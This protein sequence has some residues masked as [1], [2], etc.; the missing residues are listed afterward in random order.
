MEISI[1]A[2]SVLTLPLAELEYHPAT[3]LFRLMVV[4]DEEYGELVREVQD[5]GLVRP[6]V[7]HE[8]TVLD[9]RSR[10]RACQHAGIEQRFEVS[11]REAA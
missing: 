2:P 5:H 8:G 11:A 10:Y 4:D 9:S 3:A 6:I 1:H 7:L